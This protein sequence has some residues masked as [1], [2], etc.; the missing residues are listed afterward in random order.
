M[1][2]LIINDFYQQIQVL[3]LNQIIGNDLSLVDVAMQKAAEQC[4]S[5]LIQ[6][7]DLSNELTDTNE[8]DF[9]LPY[10]ANS[11]IYLDADAYNPGNTYNL[12][13]LALQNGQVYICTTAITLAEAF[14][15]AHWQLLGNQ[16]DLFYA[17][18]PQPVFNSQWVYNVGDEVFWRNNVYT[19]LIKTQIPGAD[20]DIQFGTI[21]NIPGLNIYPDD[22][23]NGP[24]YWGSG[25]AYTV[26]AGT[27]PTD[28]DYWTFGDNR[29]QE[30]VEKMVDIT[31]Y[32]L[33]ARISPQ[34]I[35]ALRNDKYKEAK[36][37]LTDAKNGEI[38][39]NLPV[40]QPVQ[41]CRIRYGGNVKN[42]NSY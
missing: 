5:S 23:V 40:I 24:I 35:P 28:D 31:L 33:H 27:L 36:D 4:T 11:R 2:Y 7:F 14:N 10:N 13:Q 19:C 6:R 39:P 3:N 30:L 38:T 26:A 8:W 12:N 32:K 29:C 37:W 21:N 34:N 22:P 15:A 42:I 25:T 41:G 1:S 18:Y 20:Y 16:Y 9:T 17:Q